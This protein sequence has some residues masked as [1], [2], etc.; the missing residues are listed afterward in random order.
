M[1]TRKSH[2]CSSCSVSKKIGGVL[3]CTWLFSDKP[4]VTFWGTVW[5]HP[6]YDGF[7]IPLAQHIKVSSCLFICMVLHHILVCLWF[8]GQ[9]II[10]HLKKNIRS[11]V[12]SGPYAW[13]V[14]VMLAESSLL[15][16]TAIYPRHC[17]WF[18]RPCYWLYQLSSMYIYIY[19]IKLLFSK[20]FNGFH[21][22]WC[23][24][25]PFFMI[26]KII[27]RPFQEPK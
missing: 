26:N 18:D 1:D 16:F 7:K 6:I 10:F 11:F 12:W 9:T 21:V 25:F 15:L 17:V 2:G 22:L 3:P 5:A 4:T 23:V 27:Q 24:S 19:I 8:S 13:F 14:L 20:V